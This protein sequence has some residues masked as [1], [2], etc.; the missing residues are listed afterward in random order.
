[1]DETMENKTI[2]IADDDIDQLEQLKF[3]VESFGF[4]TITASNDQEC[5]DALQD[6]KP[7]LAIL[8]LM[9][10]YDDSG[11]ILS[12]KLKKLYPDVPVMIV[13]SASSVTGI[14]FDVENESERSWIKAD[15][16][17]AKGIRPDQLHMEINKLLKL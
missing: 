9:M 5:M 17:L 15:R 3:H 7:D 2:L 16:F 13:S 14:S 4:S 10:N 11:F 1:M 12:Y 6:N 8:D